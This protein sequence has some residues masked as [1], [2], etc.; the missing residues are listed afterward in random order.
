MTRRGWGR[1]EGLGGG[2]EGK[3]TRSGQG[4]KGAKGAD[5]RRE[6]RQKVR[7]CAEWAYSSVMH[8]PAQRATR[9]SRPTSDV[10]RPRW[11]QSAR[12]PVPSKPH[13][14]N[15]PPARR[16]SLP[17]ATSTSTGM[18]ASSRKPRSAP[19]RFPP[20]SPPSPPTV[21]AN[22][23][24]SCPPVPFTQYSPTCSRTSLPP[25]S[26]FSSSLAVSSRW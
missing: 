18:H 6:D 1:E 16:R 21:P 3:R 12:A 14:A 20:Y 26:A 4:A 10:S 23:A 25:S 8:G 22:L 13:C 5:G 11:A 19:A 2:G 24:C 15:S 17:R 7:S 9:R